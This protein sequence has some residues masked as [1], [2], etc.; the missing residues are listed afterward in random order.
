MKIKYTLIYLSLLLISF[1]MRAQQNAELKSLI[2][3]SFNYFPK[4]KELEQSTL[5]SEGRLKITKSNQLPNVNGSVGYSYI[6]PI[7]QATL[8]V[9][10]GVYKTLQFQPNNNFNANIAANYVLLDFGRLKAAVQK[11]KEE[12][13]YN[14]QNLEY[15]K[16]QLAAQVAGIYFYFIYL[17]KAIAIQDSIIQYYRQNKNVVESR[18]KNGDALSVDLYNMDASIDNEQNRKVDLENAMQKQLNLLEYTT[19]KTSISSTEFNFSMN[20]ALLADY[21]KTAESKNIE[22]ALIKSKLAQAQYDVVYNQRQ[23]APTLNAIA[24]AGFRNGYQPD[25]NQNR[26]NYLAGI[27]LNVPIFTG[28]RNGSQIYVAKAT[29][30]Q[31]ELSLL[32]LNNTFKKDIKQALTDIESNKERLKN[33]ESQIKSARAL[34][35][36]TQSRYRNGIAT[37]LDL[38]YA[39][40]GI[41]RATLNQLQYEYQ[42]SIANIELARL[43]GESY[44]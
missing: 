1:G 39:A 22:Y 14:K 26:F 7:S 31:T 28:G 42:L 16:S 43:S 24:N 35:E 4:L 15:N 36:L 32:S 3:E 38:S 9:G 20:P 5:I 23:L 11:S 18:I 17:K 29:L 25:L 37:Y 2:Q 27:N 41:Q 40:N 33:S 8:P 19:G 10:P 6:D 12:I 34:L 30:K 44:W 21:L 13:T